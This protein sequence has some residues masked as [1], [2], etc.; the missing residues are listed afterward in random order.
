MAS[1][2]QKTF[3]GLDEGIAK[4][5]SD[6]LTGEG[7]IAPEDFAALSRYISGMG[8]VDK[9]RVI[10]ALEQEQQKP[11]KENLPHIT[12]PGVPRSRR[13]RMV[14]APKLEE[15]PEIGLSTGQKIIETGASSEQYKPQDIILFDELG[16][17]VVSGTGES[18]LVVSHEANGAII[19]N[20][21]NSGGIVFTRKDIPEVAETPSVESGN[22][23]PNAPVVPEEDLAII[24]GEYQPPTEQKSDE[25]ISPLQEGITPTA[26]EKPAISEVSDEFFLDEQD[27]TTPQAPVLEV[28][29]VTPVKSV[30]KVVM[31]QTVE[32]PLVVEDNDSKQLHERLNRAHQDESLGSDDSQSEA[33]A[34]VPNSN[35]TV[36][37]VDPRIT[38]DNTTESLVL[39]QKPFIGQTTEPALE[40]SGLDN[41]PENNIAGQPPSAQA[42]E[43]QVINGSSNEEIPAE[44]AEDLAP[45]PVLASDVAI[46]PATEILPDNQDASLT[47]DLVSAQAEPQTAETGPEEEVIT[48]TAPQLPVE[49]AQTEQTLGD[50]NQETDEIKAPNDEEVPIEQNPPVVEDVKNTQA[51]VVEEAVVTGDN[52]EDVDPGLND[53]NVFADTN[54]DSSQTNHGFFASFADKFLHG[55]KKGRVMRGMAGEKDASLDATMF[56]D[57][58]HHAESDDE[59]LEKAA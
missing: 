23:Q 8:E 9:E 49:P 20:A 40:Q 37:F 15:M 47:Q 36:D 26:E 14:I 19:D 41:M 31:E 58:G 48:D 13:N 16:Q 45:E 17:R 12:M 56:A 24:T 50:T 22:L 44:V 52:I 39:D 30:E 6:F 10:S 4:Y 25:D 29:S 1:V 33:I 55:N 7:E 46:P 35:P 42:Q 53:P 57:K 32:D 3:D 28:N 27:P 5:L 11:A 18:D 2:D 43:P 38:L 21:L 54:N 51:E 59:I 34:A